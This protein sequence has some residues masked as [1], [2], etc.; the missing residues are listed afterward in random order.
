MLSIVRITLSAS[1]EATR[2]HLNEV[3][4][5]LTVTPRN[6]SVGSN[7]RASVKFLAPCSNRHKAAANSS[8]APG[9]LY[10]MDF[11]GI[12]VG[13][14]PYRDPFAARECPGMVGGFDL[15]PTATQSSSCSSPS[16]TLRKGPIQ[17]P[18]PRRV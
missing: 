17:H 3:G 2:V 18:G 1:T 4:I 9:C 5:S 15:A 12:G 8:A 13:A 10:G 16:L 7:L 6:T 14:H 11:V